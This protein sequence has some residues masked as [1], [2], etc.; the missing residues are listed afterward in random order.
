MNRRSKSLVVA[1]VCGIILVIP[2]VRAASAQSYPKLLVNGNG[3][4]LTR[5]LIEERLAGMW[6]ASPSL[7]QG[8]DYRL[9][10]RLTNYFPHSV[11]LNKTYFNLTL[12]GAKFF[13]SDQYAGSGQ[14]NRYQ[15]NLDRDPL[16]P[17][18]SKSHYVYFRWDNLNPVPTP[19][20]TISASIDGNEEIP[21][22]NPPQAPVRP[23]S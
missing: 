10:V 15:S 11:S 23:T 2:L 6:V 22:P 5:L 9:T 3:L 19:L 20:V 8:V 1:T 18:K 7:R 4:A 13:L 16:E 17:T 14:A 21:L 12:N